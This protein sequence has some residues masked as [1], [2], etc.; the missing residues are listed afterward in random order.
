M[1][2]KKVVAVAEKLGVTPAQ[3]AMRWAM[4]KSFTSIPIVGARKATQLQDSLR[5]VDVEIPQEAL[6]DL[7]DISAIELGFPHD[8]LATKEVQYVIHGGTRDSIVA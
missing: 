5:A 4:Q 6:K 3:V 2:A 1:I 7:D 8:F